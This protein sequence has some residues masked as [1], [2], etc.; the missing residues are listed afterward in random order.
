MHEAQRRQLVV[1]SAVVVTVG[2]IL[3]HVFFRK[4]NSNSP[5]DGSDRRESA[6][7]NKR[8]GSFQ[9]EKAVE[10]IA[11][12]KAI[13]AD[14]LKAKNTGDE[15]VAVTTIETVQIEVIEKIG[16]AS[17]EESLHESAS[18]EDEANSVADGES[19]DATEE[20]VVK[21]IIRQE[22]GSMNHIAEQLEEAVETIMTTAETVEAVLN[23]EPILDVEEPV[24]VDV[25]ITA[26]ITAEP[27]V[28]KSPWE[29]VPTMNETN[30]WDSPEWTPQQQTQPSE[31]STVRHSDLN[32]NSA[33]F[34]PKQKSKR[35]ES[36]EQRR[37]MINKQ[38]Q[39]TASFKAR[40][41]Y[42]PKCT[43]KKCKY[44]HPMYPCRN[45]PNC[46]FGER[47]IYYHAKD[48]GATTQPKP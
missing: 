30:V 22:E 18:E 6:Q 2:V 1:G 4:P 10:S 35:L 29:D 42:W 31:T 39:T 5:T 33:P 28:P 21:E 8:R 9:T 34:V 20:E 19:T 40:C 27:K 12:A 41:R 13:V 3:Y 11:E 44:V 47:C 45:D 32:I 14:Q 23:S 37:E 48:L 46:K 24:S 7:A 17:T 36:P 15:D 38:R 43:N 16:S 26:T 25:E